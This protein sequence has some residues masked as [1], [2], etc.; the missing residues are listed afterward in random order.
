MD[1][2]T[3]TS[4]AIHEMS[5]GRITRI[6]TR[7]LLRNLSKDPVF[8]SG[9]AAAPTPLP[10]GITPALAI[11]LKKNPKTKQAIRI[12]AKKYNVRSDTIARAMM[13]FK[14]PPPSKLARYGKVSRMIT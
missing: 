8:L 5:R 1:A 3:I 12:L 9:V 14:K 4:N 2:Y 10:W 13:K 7:R 6:A 11:H